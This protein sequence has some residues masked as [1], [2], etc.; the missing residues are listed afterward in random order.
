MT[1]LPKTP[2]Q[3]MASCQGLVRSIAWT[4]HRKLPSRIDLDDLVSYGQVGLAEAARDF[5]HERGG[6]FTTFAYYRVRGAI[7]DGLAKMNWF[8][9]SDFH[10]GRYERLAHD[11]LDDQQPVEGGTASAPVADDVRWFKGVASTLAVV[12]LCTQRPGEESGEAAL[13]DP[14]ASSPAAVAMQRETD[15]K[16]HQLVDKLPADAASLIKATY[17]EGLTLKEAGARLGISKAW[18]SRLHAKALAML[19]RSLR[20]AQVAE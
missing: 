13:A 5:D 3:L 4:I 9:R 18:A 15:H 20:L 11:V 19:A 7:L 1:E 8:N 2:Q 17:F 6:Q 14:A 10:R 12:Y 16:L